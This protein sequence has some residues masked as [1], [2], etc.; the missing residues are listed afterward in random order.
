MI[1]KLAATL[2]RWGGIRETDAP[3][4]PLI[5]GYHK[6][7]P[8]AVRVLLLS[9]LA[10]AALAYGV[11][12]SIVAPLMIMP[13]AAPLIVLAGL[14]LWTLP[15]GQ[16][17]PIWAIEPL[18]VAFFAGLVLW[19]NYLAVAILNLPWLTVQR[20]TVAPLVLCF[21]ACVSI[22]QPFRERIR[23]VL[24]V[25]IMIPRLLIALNVL[26][27][28]SVLLSPDPGLSANH[29]AL[30][31]INLTVIFFV[32]CYLFSRPGFADFWV[33]ALLVMLT[34]NC[35]FGIWESR[36]QDLPWAGHIPSFLKIDD[37]NVRKI[38]TPGFARGDD[39][40]RV[41]GTSNNPLTLSEIL[42]LAVSFAVHFAVTGRT[43]LVRIAAL[44]FTI[45]SVFVILLTNSR[46]GVVAACGTIM[47][48]LLIWA[49]L[50]WRQN[51]GGLLAPAIVLTYPLALVAFIA[52]TF[53]VGRLRVEF[54][55]GGAQQASTEGRIIQWATGLPMVLQKPLGHGLGQA[56]MVLGFAP[57]G[58]LTIDSY[59]LSVLLEMGPIGFLVFYGLIL[60]AAFRAARTAVDY[61]QEGELGLLIPLAITLLNFFIVK[62]VLSQE[63]NH[64]FIFMIMGAVMALAHRA[65][66]S[67]R[68]A[69][70]VAPAPAQERG[71]R[72][73]FRRR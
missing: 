56:A 48:Y 51:K 25:D 47:F 3:A 55:G 6:S 10:V 40:Y 66:S 60:R 67:A 33:R 1:R 20:I 41:K 46:L 35:V 28:V 54:W 63:T 32:S 59:W 49:L 2:R 27:G 31:L 65:Q 36:L 42:G 14:I 21:L 22:S 13:F 23:A 26:W 73:G 50:R 7:T 69:E 29:F 18:L 39:T 24:A 64:P 4:Q 19:P 17:A 53:L 30:N 70:A 72:V 71:L 45:L 15:P 52:S 57:S 43:W 5:A 38:L 16:N 62:G 61:G 58:M 37:P 44:M 8:R 9:I 12:F 11:A 68:L 34:I